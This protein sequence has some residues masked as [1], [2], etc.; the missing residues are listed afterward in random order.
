MDAILSSLQLAALLKPSAT[1]RDAVAAA[2]P[3]VASLAASG[4][5]LPPLVLLSERPLPSLDLMRR[6]RIRL[7]LMSMMFQRQ[8]FLKHKFLRYLVVDASPQL[9]MQFLCMREDRIL[10]PQGDFSVELRHALDLNAAFESPSR[11]QSCFDIDGACRVDDDKG[12]IAA[13]RK[14][15]CC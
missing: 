6:S 9:G 14:G 4:V 10:L 12:V 13:A 3:L 2:A 1:L 11:L 15:C 5:A 8:L 7:D